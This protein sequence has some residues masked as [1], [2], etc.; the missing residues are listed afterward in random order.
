VLRNGEQKRV[1]A[2]PAGSLDSPPSD[3]IVRLRPLPGV[4]PYGA[5]RFALKILKRRY[6]LRVVTIGRTKLKGARGATRIN[7]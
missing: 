3:F 4:A 2:A 5:L 7:P 1:P 6:G